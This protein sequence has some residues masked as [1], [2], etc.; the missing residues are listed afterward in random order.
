MSQ[1]Q[2]KLER[3]QYAYSSN[4]LLLAG[5]I[6]DVFVGRWENPEGCEGRKLRRW[7]A[8]ETVPGGQL[9]CVLHLRRPLTIEDFKPIRHPSIRPIAKSVDSSIEYLL[10]DADIVCTFPDGM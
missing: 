8:D 2:H 5:D 1:A 9:M 6:H 7:P 3:G 10:M 4:S